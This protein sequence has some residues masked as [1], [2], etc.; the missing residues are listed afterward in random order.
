MSELTALHFPATAIS[1]ISITQELLFF[2]KIFFY[3]AVESDESEE[4]SILKDLC[5]G[6]P[7]IPFGDDLERFKALLR[8]LKGHAGEFYSGQLSAMSLEHMEN[9]DKTTVKDLI[10]TITGSAES[11]HEA[12]KTRETLWQSRLLLKLAEIMTKEEQELQNELASIAEKEKSLFDTLKGDPELAKTLS[13]PT[14]YPK[15]PVRPEVILKSWGHLFLADTKQTPWV[16]TTDVTEYAESFFEA[17]ESLS[18][19]RPIRLCRIPL[20]HI[21]GMSID[22]FLDRRNNFRKE[23]ADQLET[24]AH[25]LADTAMAGQQ[26]NT[27]QEWTHLAAELTK[28]VAES[29][30]WDLSGTAPATPPPHM[31]IYLCNRSLREIVAHICRSKGPKHGGNEPAHGIIILKSNKQIECGG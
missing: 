19:Q 1:A 2:N 24:F 10:S 6:Y 17:C 25:L 29:G 20:P 28:L 4:N 22:T 8:E 23:G 13:N 15:Y 12:E 27:L 18:K 7:P 26:E 9:R 30:S 14:V 5:I 31:E 3:H 11:G 16:L 21:E